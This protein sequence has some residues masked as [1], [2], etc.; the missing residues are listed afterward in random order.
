VVFLEW[1]SKSQMKVLWR[2]RRSGGSLTE[3]SAI[4]QNDKSFIE[5]TAMC[6]QI[7]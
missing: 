7:Y 3:C 5:D 4:T 1:S 2:I 6:N